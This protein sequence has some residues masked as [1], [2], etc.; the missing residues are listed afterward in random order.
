[1][2]HNNEPTIKSEPIYAGSII[3]VQVDTVRLPNGKTATR[4]LVKHPGAVAVIPLTS[5]NRLV[6]VE[7]YRKPLEKLTIELP[8]GKLEAGEDLLDCA[9]RELAEETGYTA[10]TWSH[11]VS[12]YTSPGFADEQI[13]L[14]VAEDLLAGE[15]HPDDDEFVN[16]QEITLDDAYAF[17]QSGNICDA[18]TVA[19]IYAWHNRELKNR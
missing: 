13:H 16:T 8:A 12:F 18:K 1:M 19:A 5:D 6:V 14:Y 4:E 11:L 2:S 3:Q 9:K 17:I 7:Q 10:K 15:S